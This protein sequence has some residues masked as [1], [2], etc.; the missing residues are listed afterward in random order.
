M[1]EPKKFPLSVLIVED[2]LSTLE[3][4]NQVLSQK[5]ETVYTA[6]N[7]EEGFER[8][9]LESPDL[10]IS[11]MDMP[12][13]NG[14]EFLKAIRCEDHDTAFILLTGF[15]NLDILVAAIENGITAFLPKP[16]QLNTLTSKLEGIAYTKAL[17]NEVFHTQ[18]LL[19]QYKNIV[20]SSSIVSKA[21]PKG[22]ITFANDMFCQIS[23]YSRE[24]LIGKS[25]S[26]VRDPQTPSSLFTELWNTIQ[27]KKTWHGLLH[28]RAKDGSRY[29]VKTTIAPLLD[30][31]GTIV[32]YIGLRED[33]SELQR[34]K[35]EALSAAKSKG[36]FLANMSHEIRTP[37]NGIV[38]FTALLS[39]S[40][41]DT[42]QK[43]YLDII[44]SSTQTLMGV[45]NNILDLSKLES[46]KV[47]LD[48]T[49][50]NPIIEFEKIAQL[51]SAKSDEKNITFKTDITPRI[52]ECILIDLLRIQQIVSNLINNAIKFTPDFG[53]IIFYVLVL[54][55]NSEEKRIRIGVKDSGIGISPE[56]QQ[57]IFKPFS[58][59]DGS[60]TR[61]FGGTGLGL[62]I[63][64]NLVSL[65][66][67]EL[68]VE[69]SLGK[70][71]NF[72]FEI[73]V[74]TCT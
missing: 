5:V 26:I 46:G 68:K 41:L 7:G 23:G 3:Q 2:E 22:V 29:T 45:I 63:S 48:L 74:K 71:S 60:I 8:Y 70:G 44:N 40:K 33:V 34:A 25:H 37:M 61:R 58:Q 30:H 20:D 24:E 16:I 35:E 54:D 51:F 4:L 55:H 21:D 36:E 64:S 62:S 6:M 17:R 47:E 15:K 53:E 67:S 56:Q 72:Y 31:N 69:S 52:S 10:I 65:M 13:M 1:N 57:Q 43:R 9:K 73:R 39:Q 11:D 49:P 50:I 19:E 66:E 12:V 32:E 38:G 42:N 18:L 59:A 27:A 28:N 14:I